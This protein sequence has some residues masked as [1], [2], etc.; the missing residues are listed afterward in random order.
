MHF[1]NI[2]TWT[3]LLWKF[4]Q[5]LEAHNER[6]CKLFL[7][8]AVVVSTLYSSSTDPPSIED[9]LYKCS[10]PFPYVVLVK[11]GL[12]QKEVNVLSAEKING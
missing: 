10:E 1:G 11:R 8:A 4:L 5:Q 3:I 6:K 7:K 12:L 2:P 9:D